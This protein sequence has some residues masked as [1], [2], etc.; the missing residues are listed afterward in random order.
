MSFFL[1]LPNFLQSQEWKNSGN[2]GL[3]FSAIGFEDWATGGENA[4]SIVFLLKYNVSY[5]DSSFQWENDIDLGYGV[6]Y[7]DEFDWRKNQDMININSKFGHKAFSDFNYAAQLNFKTQFYDGYD[8]RVSDSNIVSKLFSPAYLNLSVGLD[9][10]PNE[11]L[12]LFLSPVSGRLIIMADDSLS[13]IG[14]YGA[15]VGKT[16]TP[17]LGAN[18]VGKAKWEIFENVFY[19]SKLELFLNFTPKNPDQVKNV[20]GSWENNFVLK[21]N[22]YLSANAFIHLMYDHDIAPLLQK[23]YFG[24]LGLTFKL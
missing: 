4:S 21:V 16:V 23:K 18:F 9:Y 11:H 10:K 17:E 22:D 15:E 14:A 13:D 2:I 19:D 5:I 8:Y 20:D 7:S 24:G 6:N 12:S 1:L 3:Q